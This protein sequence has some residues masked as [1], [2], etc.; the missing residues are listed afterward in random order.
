MDMDTYVD[1]DMGIDM[2]MDMNNIQ[3]KS[4]QW[5]NVELKNFGKLYFKQRCHI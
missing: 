5:K 3:Q 2:E 1:M 4:E